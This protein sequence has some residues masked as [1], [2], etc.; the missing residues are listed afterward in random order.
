[1]SKAPQRVE[2]RMST[3]AFSI[4]STHCMALGLRP[5]LR[6]MVFSGKRD[7]SSAR[8]ARH[9]SRVILTLALSR[10]SSTPMACRDC[11]LMLSLSL[12]M[13]L[14]DA[15]CLQ[16]CTKTASAEDSTIY[17]SQKPEC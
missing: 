7:A 3:P 11:N 4:I 13:R 2:Y 16:Q 8:A 5:W 12:V 6:L 10:T 14:L 1:M 9:A 17:S 15:L